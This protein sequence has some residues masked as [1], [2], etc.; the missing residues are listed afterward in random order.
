MQL[1]LID[2]FHLFMSSWL[3]FYKPCKSINFSKS[4]SLNLHV[5][6]QP[7]RSSKF[8]FVSILMFPFSHLTSIWIFF[9]FFNLAK[10]LSSIVSLLSQL[11]W[12]YSISFSFSFIIL[13][14]FASDKIFSTFRFLNYSLDFQRFIKYIINFFGW[15]LP[16]I[17]IL[18]L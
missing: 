15:N 3:H 12:I 4:F 17:S 16:G 10:D 1:R 6:T 7:Q 8:L 13:F 11:C 14:F 9:S 5:R 2:M 18:A